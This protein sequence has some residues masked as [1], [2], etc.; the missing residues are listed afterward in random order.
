MRTRLVLGLGL[1]ALACGG[2]A[3]RMTTMDVPTNAVNIPLQ[4]ILVD[5]YSR[6]GERRRVVIRDSDQWNAFWKEAAAGRGAAGAPPEIDFTRDMALVAA[7]GTRGTGGHR[8]A[9]DSVFRSEGRLLVV[10]REVSPGAKCMTTQAVT[11]PL[12]A[13]R[14]ARSTDPV[15]FLERLEVQD[16]G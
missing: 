2:S 15:T 4:P 7:M 6:I 8:I 16:C 14:V 12:A 11:A 1:A 13:V 5:Q 3:Q 9:I 10:V